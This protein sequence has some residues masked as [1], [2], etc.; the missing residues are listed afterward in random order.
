MNY[1]T[2]PKVSHFVTIFYSKNI[3]KYIILKLIEELG[4]N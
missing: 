4:P 1:T 3:K 2:K